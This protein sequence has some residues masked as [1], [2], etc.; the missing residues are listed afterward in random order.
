MAPGVSLQVGMV[1]RDLDAVTPFYRDGLGL[2]HIRDAVLPH[3]T[4]RR[5]LCGGGIFKLL[6]PKEP[7]TASNPP[8]HKDTATGLRWFSYNVTAIEEVVERCVAHGGRVVQPLA[9]WSGTKVVLVEDPEGGCW[10]ELI[11]PKPQE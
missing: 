9:D 8:G 4:Q 1:V 2:E 11:E 5:F 10:I 7:P 6:Q 3:G